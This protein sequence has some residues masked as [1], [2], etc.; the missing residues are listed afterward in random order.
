MRKLKLKRFVE[1]TIAR[2]EFEFRVP[3]LSYS[4]IKYVGV[5]K[6]AVS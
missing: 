4:D 3:G 1:L 6:F 2:S 5:S